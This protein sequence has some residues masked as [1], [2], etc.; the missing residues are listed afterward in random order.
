MLFISRELFIIKSEGLSVH[1]KQITLRIY[2]SLSERLCDTNPRDISSSHTPE[3]K[4]MK[5]L[6]PIADWRDLKCYQSDIVARIIRNGLEANYNQYLKQFDKQQVDLNLPLQFLWR[7]EFLRR[8]PVYRNNWH[9]TGIG[10]DH[11]VKKFG[12]TKSCPDP[13]VLCPVDLWFT[14]LTRP[15]S[16]Y[17]IQPLIDIRNPIKDSLAAVEGFI[18]LQREI[19]GC[20]D[21]RRPSN[22]VY[23]KYLRVL[24]ALAAKVRLKTIGKEIF[25]TYSKERIKQKIYQAKYVQAIQID[26]DLHKYKTKKINTD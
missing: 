12:L 5:N 13:A 14:D 4:Q 2:M 6:N 22:S 15:H 25:S 26:I 19:D 11:S 7:W 1:G 16:K 9:K 8:L 23:P 17:Y 20:A 18:L 3:G 10:I 21:R 24:D